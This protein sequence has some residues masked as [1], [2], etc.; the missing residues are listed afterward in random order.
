MNEKLHG[1][2]FNVQYLELILREA[3]RTFESLIEFKMKGILNYQVDDLAIDK[4]A[5]GRLADQ[6]AKYT[7][8]TLFKSEVEKVI[9]ARNRLAHRLFIS[10]EVHKDSLPEEIDKDVE[11]AVLHGETAARLGDEVFALMQH[12]YFDPVLQDWHIPS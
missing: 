4:L 3:L 11:E 2:M 12:Y 10:V 1:A 7:A 8:N 6:Y 5:L 9:K